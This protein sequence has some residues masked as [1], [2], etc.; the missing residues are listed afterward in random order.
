M[1]KPHSGQRLLTP[2]PS[3]GRINGR[4]GASRGR[5]GGQT[6]KRVYGFLSGFPEPFIVAASDA[7]HNTGP[8]ERMITEPAI[9]RTLCSNP[10]L[11]DGPHLILLQA[12]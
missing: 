7:G 5:A 11:K 6:T 8:K 10:R 3:R 2:M 12:V 9:W 4:T 1:H